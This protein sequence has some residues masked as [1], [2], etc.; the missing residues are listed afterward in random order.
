M[1]RAISSI[2]HGDLLGAFKYN[3]LVLIVFPLLVYIWV[4]KIK[5]EYMMLF[6]NNSQFPVESS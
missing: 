1:I 3:K 4:T 6:C 2:F 5:K